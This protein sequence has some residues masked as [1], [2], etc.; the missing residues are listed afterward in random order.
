MILGLHADM[1]L[2]LKL[3]EGQ[4]NKKKKKK[5]RDAAQNKRPQYI[6]KAYGTYPHRKKFGI[7]SGVLIAQ[8]A[9]VNEIIIQRQ[10]IPITPKCR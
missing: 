6:V 4:F 3:Y 1:C 2:L 7:Y 10:S 9:T 8:D 5:E